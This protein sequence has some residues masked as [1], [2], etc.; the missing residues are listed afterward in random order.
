VGYSAITRVRGLDAIP[1]S[2]RLK[3]DMEIWHW[4]ATT[5]AYAATTYWY[6]MPGA[7]CNRGPEEKEASRPILEDTQLGNSK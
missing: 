2:S 6:A 5:M 4:K 7:T 1:F 3:F